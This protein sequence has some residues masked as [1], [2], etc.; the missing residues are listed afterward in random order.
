MEDRAVHANVGGTI[1]LHRCCFHSARSFGGPRHCG[2]C[3]KCDR[4]DFYFGSLEREEKSHGCDERPMMGKLEKALREIKSWE[5]DL[6]F[7]K[8]HERQE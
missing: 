2:V 4:V 1:Q 7:G 8:N 6:L 5:V 3:C